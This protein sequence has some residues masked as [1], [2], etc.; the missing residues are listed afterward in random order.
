MT[1]K[2]DETTDKLRRLRLINMADH[3]AEGLEKEKE[4]NHG[5]LW[6]M[7]YLIETE[8]ES[9]WIRAIENRHRNSRLIDKFLPIDF[10]F[11][12][13]LSMQKNRSIL[14]RLLECDF[15]E[16]HKDI[17]FIGHPGTG[18]T[19]LAKTIAHQACLKNKR[20]LFTTAID[21]IN[22]LIAAKADHSLLKKLKYYQSPS[23]LLC[24]ELGFLSLDEQSSSLFF[25]VL[26]A[27]HGVV[28]T[29]VTTNLPFSRWG[30]IFQ[31]TV[32]AQAIADRLVHN[33]EIILLEGPSYR[34][35]SK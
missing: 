12:F 16:E 20:V 15:I 35:K 29:I 19:R 26:S 11:K 4:N 32:I 9:R 21:M 31:S 2:I 22:H 28:S 1:T 33:S 5:F 8:N 6:L 24:D 17:I 30:E 3:L 25:Q 23:L 14:L 13:H 10:D 34:Q 27:R 18:K 7:D